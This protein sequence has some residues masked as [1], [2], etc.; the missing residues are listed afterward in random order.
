MSATPTTRAATRSPFGVRDFRLLWLGEA[1]SALGDQ[2]ALIAL[3]WLALVLTGSALAL[4]S[5][6]ALMAVPRALLMLVG[7]VWVDRLSPRRVMLGSNAVRL[8]AVSLL[9]AAVLAGAAE[10][11][12]LYAFALVFGV[13]DAFFYPAQ[14]SI[15]PELVD[16][17]QLQ[18]AVGITQGTAQATVLVGPAVAGVIIA[19]LGSSG[20]GPGSAGIGAALL[21]DGASF[22]AS[23]ATLWLIH[24]RHQAPSTQTSV[25]EAIGEAVRFLVGFPTL[26]AIVVLSLVANLLIVG[27]VEVGLP[28][29]AYLRFPEGAAAYGV[30]MSA[31]GGGSLVGYAAGAILPKPR[32]ALLG[33]VIMV[34]LSA[35][36]LGVAALAF[37]DQTW[38]AAAAAI[39]T[40][41]ALGYGNLLGITWIQARVPQQLMGRVMSVLMVGSMG[42]V[43]VSELVA[44]AVVQVS[45]EGLLLVA[46]LGMTLSSLGALGSARIRNLG[47]IPPLDAGT[48]ANAAPGAAPTEPNEARASAEGDEAQASA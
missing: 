36:G 18:A 26:L 45:L 37:I 25:I 33:S 2:F 20:S 6:M 44:G 21:L 10:L 27:P 17:D 19:A 8:V 43:P 29:L 13:A 15:V 14:T 11:W 46:G 41:A 5:V 23:L 22:L 16:S 24:G 1:V 7:G 39:V 4:G 28:V 35:S 30:I 34:V 31:F 9:G 32:R 12:M 38:M 48:D 3:P 42:L 47:H 40:G